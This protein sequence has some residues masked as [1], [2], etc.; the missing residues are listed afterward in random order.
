MILLE[1]MCA[2][3][4]VA[5]VILSSGSGRG[6]RDTSHSTTVIHVP[7]SSDPH[8]SLRPS[9]LFG[10]ESDSSWHVAQCEWRLAPMGASVVGERFQVLPRSQHLDEWDGSRP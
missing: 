9:R 5:M 10:R 6:T 4:P 1:R 2:P 3:L 7:P 8:V